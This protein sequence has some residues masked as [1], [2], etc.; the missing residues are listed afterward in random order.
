MTGLITF[1]VVFIV[2]SQVTAFIVAIVARLWTKETEPVLLRGA[3]PDKAYFIVADFLQSVDDDRFGFPTGVFEIDEKNTTPQRVVAR[4]VDFKG[5]SGFRLARLVVTLPMYIAA[6]A[7]EVNWIV[8]LIAFF[9]A[10]AIAFYIAVPILILAL[11]EL[12]LRKLLRGRVAATIAPTTGD[13]EG[14]LVTFELRGL[15]A[16][17]IEPQL[18]RAFQAPELPATLRGLAPAP[19]VTAEVPERDQYRTILGVAGACAAVVALVIAVSLPTIGSSGDDSSSPDYTNASDTS[20]TGAYDSGAGNDDTEET[21]EDDTDSYDDTDTEDVELTDESSSDPSELAAQINKAE[22]V[23]VDSGSSEEDVAVAGRLEQRATRLLQRHRDTLRGPTFAELSPEAE[24]K[25]AATTK[26]ASAVS[27]TVDPAKKF[28]DWEIAEPPPVEK[29]LAYYHAAEDEYGVGWQYLA[30]IHFLETRV[31]RIRGTSPV[32]A[33]GP[34]QFI[35]GTWARYGKGDINSPRDSIMA[36]ARLLVANGAPDDMRSA[37]YHYNPSRGYVRAIELH[38]E[39]ME[40]DERAFHG[41]YNWQV[42][43]KHRR[44]TYVLPEGYPE[45]RPIA[46][47]E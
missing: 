20:D 13:V 15:S 3:A 6:S 26:A 29:L 38:A 2:V 23:I 36:A 47:P 11:T 19:P 16:L 27:T 46:L 10:V 42:F 8:G 9:F 45:E 7:A 25:M 28:P 34:M 33:Q 32:G 41:Y 30:A 37:L 17:A 24:E 5:S 4:E 39:Q 40:A 22:E 14:S 21:Y 43:Y 12:A 18:K 44:G 1:L 35:P 31:G